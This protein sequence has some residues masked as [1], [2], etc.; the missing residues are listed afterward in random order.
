MNAMTD[1]DVPWPPRR[2]PVLLPSAEVPDMDF[3]RQPGKWTNVDPRGESVKY[4]KGWAARKGYPA[5]LCYVME[6]NSL[7][8]AF[9]REWDEDAQVVIQVTAD[10]VVTANSGFKPVVKN[11]WI[12]GWRRDDPLE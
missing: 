9:P 2:I 1:P 11:G 12:T 7:T 8:C 5:R 6:R 10:G 4:L 3:A